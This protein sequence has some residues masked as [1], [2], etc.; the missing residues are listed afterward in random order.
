MP[1][2]EPGAR[3]MKRGVQVEAEAEAEVRGREPGW[4]RL[5]TEPL[6]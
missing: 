3:V 1:G 2:M 6:G 4:K 5:E